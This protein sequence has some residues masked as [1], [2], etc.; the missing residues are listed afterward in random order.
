MG[1]KI[2]ALARCKFS[3][4]GQ[5]ER[6]SCTKLRARVFQ[7][8]SYIPSQTLFVIIKWTDYGIP[9]PHNYDQDIYILNCEFASSAHKWDDDSDDDGDGPNVTIIRVM[10]PS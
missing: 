10:P 7:A 8:F 2:A 3:V 6:S 1:I 4:K 5:E 9:C